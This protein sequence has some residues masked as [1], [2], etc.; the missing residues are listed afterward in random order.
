MKEKPAIF[1]TVDAVVA[2]ATS[3]IYFIWLCAFKTLLYFGSVICYTATL[4]LCCCYCFAFMIY[5]YYA[6]INYVLFLLKKQMIIYLN[7]I[8][9]RKQMIPKNKICN[10]LWNHFYVKIKNEIKICHNSLFQFIQVYHSQFLNNNIGCLN[11]GGVFMIN[12]FLKKLPKIVFD[13]RESN[14]KFTCLLSSKRGRLLK[15]KSFIDVL[16]ITNI[17]TFI[18]IVI[19]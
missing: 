2:S 17:F 9:L 15:A 10:I 11:W 13:Q 12:L 3:C 1:W 7:I 6:F 19:Y 14:E 8:F 18:Y 4:L 5:A 16:K